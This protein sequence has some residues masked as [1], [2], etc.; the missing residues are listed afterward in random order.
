MIWNY[1]KVLSNVGLSLCNC[2]GSRICA[3]VNSGYKAIASLCYLRTGSPLIYL[4]ANNNKEVNFVNKTD[5][6]FVVVNINIFGN[7]N[8]LSTNET[9][10]HVPVALVILAIS[11][12]AILV[13][14]YCCPELLPDLVR[15]MIWYFRANIRYLH[16]LGTLSNQSLR[17]TDINYPITK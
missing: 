2:L 4:G 12:A 7:N 8:K 11:I 15:W 9:R 16:I 5:K 10:S 17:S 13:V 14:S 6:P 1:V 3:G